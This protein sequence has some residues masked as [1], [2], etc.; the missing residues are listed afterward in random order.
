MLNTFVYQILDL[1]LFLFFFSITI[2]YLN[3]FLTD[4]ND[5]PF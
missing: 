5:S 2:Q 3:F 4:L 1:R